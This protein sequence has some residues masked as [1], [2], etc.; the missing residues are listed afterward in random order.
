MIDTTSLHIFSVVWDLI[1]VACTVLCI[2]LFVFWLYRDKEP[3][4]IPKRKKKFNDPLEEEE[5]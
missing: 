5:E 4:P 1:V 2:S 3:P